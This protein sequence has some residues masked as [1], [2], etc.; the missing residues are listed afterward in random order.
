MR[1]ADDRDA[2]LWFD[3]WLE[4]RIEDALAATWPHDRPLAVAY[5]SDGRLL[6]RYDEPGCGHL[7]CLTGV[8]HDDTVAIDT[9]WLLACYLPRPQ[10]TLETVFDEVTGIGEEVLVPPGHSDWEAWWYAEARGRGVATALLQ[11]AT[12][13]LMAIRDE[14]G[15]NELNLSAWEPNPAAQSFAARHGFRHAR[16]FWRMERPHGPVGRPEWPAGVVMRTFDGSERALRDFNDAYNR[17]FATHYHYVRSSLEALQG[18]KVM[19]DQ[20]VEKAGTYAYRDRRRRKRDMRALWIV[21]LNAA[22][23]QNGLTYNALM[24]GLKKAGVV[25]DRKVLADIAVRDAQTFARIAE[26]ARAS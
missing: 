15:L 18:Q 11:A 9:P 21:R 13:R 23:R 20:A 12:A 3:R 2:A 26:V 16:N 10:P 24:S 14:H 22:A 19:V 17:S 8:V 7:D 6:R 4:A 5:V 1:N 25:L